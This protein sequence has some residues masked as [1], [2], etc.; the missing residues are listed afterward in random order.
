ME[1]DGYEDLVEVGRGGFGVVYRAWQPSLGRA[2]A[3]K[4]VAGSG[5]LS[6]EDRRRFE[7]EALA[8]G[9]LSWHPNIAGIYGT[10]ETSAGQP[11]LA[12]EYF[13]AGSLGDRIRQRGALPP[14]AVLDYG[15]SLAGALQ[16]AH[17]AGLLHRD[18]KPDNVLV[19]D[20]GVPKLADFGIAV[21]A[22]HTRTASG[23]ITGSVAHVAPEIL[24][25]EP[26]SERSDVY[27]LGSTL[28]ELAAGHSAFVR[29]DDES[30]V[31]I[32]LRVASHPTPDLRP[33]GI[34]GPVA[35]VVEASMT[36]SPADR[37]QSMEAFGRALQ[38]AQ[39]A[40]GQPI[41][42]LPVAPDGTEAANDEPATWSTAPITVTLPAEANSGDGTLDAT[43]DFASVNVASVATAKKPR[44][45]RTAVIAATVVLAA[46]LAGSLAFA[47][48]EGDSSGDPAATPAGTDASSPTAS[49]PSTT[50]TSPATS[51]T[52]PNPETPA[53]AA[54]VDIETG[55]SPEGVAATDQAVWVATN[56]GLTRVAPETDSVE[57]TIELET[58]SIGPGLAGVA[59][60]A[61]AA[62]VVDAT[63]ATVTRVDAA[64]GAVSDTIE[65]RQG[66]A[67]F[68]AYISATEDAV[69][70][71]GTELT[72]IDASNNLARNIEID[73]GIGGCEGVAATA[74]AVWLAA[75]GEDTVIRVDPTTNAVDDTISVGSSPT[76]V[77]ATPT[78]VWVANQLD[79]T[80]QRIDPDT[81]DVIETIPIPDSDLRGVAATNDDVWAI[82]S[83][84][85]LYR[86]D[87][88]TNE[89][90]ATLETGHRSSPDGYI[91]A[92]DDAVW[93]TSTDDD[94]VTRIDASAV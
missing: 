36:K 45:A 63:D 73:C 22:G 51:T 65:L 41:T 37:F 28:F 46:M 62:W 25:G 84:G 52:N 81:N 15:V 13:V 10:G 55:P 23:V 47:A 76:G 80:V 87:P 20:F 24:N 39:R 38:H 42:A 7:R 8:M 43:H 4:V 6:A 34:P 69:W 48:R 27:S 93:V 19:D 35:D 50:T 91:A 67:S 92:T 31:A 94:L 16:S 21:I 11:Y 90:T 56:T 86:I 14:A 59:A 82:D 89:V 61:D 32:A 78:A 60:T 71:L 40:T 58:S 17:D 57:T 66:A 88:D 75:G 85:T 53:R 18:I 77:A 49:E 79:E 64:S 83:G 12:M 29:P 68:P 70:V 33:L 44:R 5:L 1:V 30:I 9:Q 74:D 26:A 72:R 54:M 2:V 3:L